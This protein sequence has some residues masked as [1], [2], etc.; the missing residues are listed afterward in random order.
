MQNDIVRKTKRTFGHFATFELYNVGELVVSRC[1]PKSNNEVTRLLALAQAS[2][3]ESVTDVLVVA[4]IIFIR[5][6]RRFTALAPFNV[7]NIV[8]S[9]TI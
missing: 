4:S 1:G 8:V 3:V 9:A 6:V 7:A 5:M 2:L